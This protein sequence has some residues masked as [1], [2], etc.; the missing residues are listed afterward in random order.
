MRAVLLCDFREGRASLAERGPA[1]AGRVLLNTFFDRKVPCIYTHLPVGDYLWGAM[2]EDEIA[3]LALRTKAH[4]FVQKEHKALDSVVLLGPAAERKATSDC[5]SSLIDGRFERQKG[6]MLRLARPRDALIYVLEEN[7]LAYEDFRRGGR[8]DAEFTED[9]VRRTLLYARAATL[10][11]GFSVLRTRS[12]E[13]TARAFA[14]QLP[15]MEARAGALAGGGRRL[16]DMFK[17]AEQGGAGSDE[18]GEGGI[19][20]LSQLVARVFAGAPEEQALAAA[21][22]SAGFAVTRAPPPPGAPP[23]ARAAVEVPGGGRAVAVCGHAWLRALRAAGGGGG[24][25]GGG[26]DD[27][28]GGVAALARACRAAAAP[29]S[30]S[31]ARCC[32]L[33]VLTL[34]LAA[35]AE[36]EKRAAKAAALKAARAGTYKPPPP[37]RGRLEL[38][39]ELMLKHDIAVEE[40]AALGGGWTDCEPPPEEFFKALAHP[41]IPAFVKRKMADEEKYQRSKKRQRQEE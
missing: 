39:A 5:I 9:V 6:A 22:G 3:R 34:G 10:A 4:V 40:V 1:S 11:Q 36:A 25:G 2:P 33:R 37:S 20:D 18:G 32:A 29:W 13:E 27:G 17:D 38:H 31:D 15:L 30:G 28:A 7:T 19:E 41:A 12:I 23:F 8:I 26:G 14:A 35:A 24:G 16:R 21:L